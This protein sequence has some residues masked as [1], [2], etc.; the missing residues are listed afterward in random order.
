MSRSDIPSSIQTERLE[1]SLKRC[2][3]VG[4][5]RGFDLSEISGIAQAAVSGGLALLEVTMNSNDPESQIRRIKETSA[6]QLC[7]GAGTVTDVRLFEN[8]IEAGAEFIVAPGLDHSIIRY[9][10]QNGIPVIPGA[11]TPTEI[12]RAWDWGAFMV[13]VFPADPLGVGYIRSLR[14]VFP[15]IRFMPTGGVTRELAGAYFDAGASAVGVG[16]PLFDFRAIR[17][18]DWGSIT[19]RCRE[20]VQVAKV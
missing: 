17:A 3:V 4:I 13:K 10:V 2:P 5:V 11:M 8:A 12:Y 20:F 16:G 15:E 18:R 6:G 1:A 7:V 19:E 9:G 14:P